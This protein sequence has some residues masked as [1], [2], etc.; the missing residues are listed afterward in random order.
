MKY[1]LLL[2]LLS[3]LLL[4]ACTNNRTEFDLTLIETGTNT[5]ISDAKIVVSGE[6]WTGDLSFPLVRY[7]IDTMYTDEKGYA[8][9]SSE[10]EFDFTDFSISKNE[11]FSISL[12]DEHNQLRSGEKKSYQFEMSGFAYLKF[13]IVDSPDVDESGIRLH[14]HFGGSSSKLYTFGDHEINGIIP[15]NRTHRYT[16]VLGDQAL[17]EGFVTLEKND[18]TTIVLEY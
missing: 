7:T 13:L 5:P 9:Y 17:Q 1:A 10:E 8:E 11:Y 16:Y 14:T 4:A 18:S 2:A 15:S 3:L 12:E 6:R